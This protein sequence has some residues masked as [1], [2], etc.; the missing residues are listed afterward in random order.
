MKIFIAI[1]IVITIISLIFAVMSTKKY[2]E[3]TY[4]PIVLS[5]I[6]LCVGVIFFSNMEIISKII[7]IAIFGIILLINK[8]LWGKIED[9]RES[10]E[11]KTKNINMQFYSPEYYKNFQEQLDNEISVLSGL[12]TGLIGLGAL[13]ANDGKI[14]GDDIEEIEKIYTQMCNEIKEEVKNYDM[15]NIIVYAKSE[16]ITSSMQELLATANFYQKESVEAL[17]D[18]LIQYIIKSAIEN[19]N[20]SYLKDKGLLADSALHPVSAFLNIAYSIGSLICILFY[21]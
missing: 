2:S 11:K 12:L 17:K 15:D 9:N 3:T 4:S 7:I 16:Q 20:V 18:K 5:F 14:N 1:S 21:F 19:T 10:I 6:L 13:A 8:F